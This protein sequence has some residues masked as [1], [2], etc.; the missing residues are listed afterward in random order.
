MKL[1]LIKKQLVL[2]S[3]LLIVY[4]YQLVAYNLNI[5]TNYIYKH[6]TINQ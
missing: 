6:I 5:Q 2:F 4:D 1:I 3:Y